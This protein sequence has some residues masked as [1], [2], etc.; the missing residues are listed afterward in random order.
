MEEYYERIKSMNKD[1][2]V[3]LYELFITNTYALAFQ[4]DD[5]KYITKYLPLSK[6]MIEEML[7]QKGAIGC[8]QQ[9][10]KSNM[11][12]WIC[13]DF[14]SPD[15]EN[16]D[17]NY[18]YESC[19]VPLKTICDKYHIRYLTEFS[20]RRGIHLWIIFSHLIP[21]D[22]AFYILSYLKKK[23]ILQIGELKSVNLDLFP[24][25]D[26][27]KGNIV[28]KQ[29][30]L[31]LSI[32]KSGSRSWLFEGQFIN[33]LDNNS[34]TFLESQF[35][36]LKKYKVNDYEKVIKIIGIDKDDYINKLKYIKY[37]VYSGLKLSIRE[38]IDILSR[39]KVYKQIFDRLMQGKAYRQDWLVIMGTFSPLHDGG[40]FVKEMYSIFPN[41]DMKKT[42]DNIGRYIDKYFPATF[43]YLYQIYDLDIEESLNKKDTGYAY[44]LNTYGI[45][46][47]KEVDQIISPK[48]EGEI[49]VEDTL[50]KEI[51]Y[52]LDNDEVL[53][54]SIWNKLNSFKKQDIIYISEI[55]SKVLNGTLE[56]E[57][58]PSAF[59][60]DRRE[61]EMKTRRLVS[62]DAFD[63]VLTTH[64]SLLLQYSIK[65]RWNSF[66]YNLSFCSREDIFYNWYSSWSEYINKIKAFLEVP[67][68]ETYNVFTIDL[69]EFY[70]HIDYL[71]VYSRFQGEFSEKEN[72]LF[73]F[74]IDYN[75]S[76]MRKIYEGKRKGVPQGPAYARIISEMYLD[77]VI[78]SI[79]SKYESST[80]H[81]FRYVDD[82]IVFVKPENDA[83]EMY[84]FLVSNLISYGLPINEEK[85]CCY[86]L[87]KSLTNEQRREILRK[88][89]F[90]YDLQ[91]VDYKGYVTLVERRRD[92]ENF[93]N[94]KT[95]EISDISMFYSTKTYEE[96]SEIYFRRYACKIMES[97]I[98]R[99]SAFRRFYKYMFEHPNVLNEALLKNFF[100]KVPLNSINFGNLLGE[101][102][103]VIQKH[104][105]SYDSL[106]RI[107][108][109]YLNTINDEKLSEEY[110]IL[111]D[112]LKKIIITLEVEDEY[113]L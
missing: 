102:Y 85:S 18:I 31:P 2:S 38:A 71:S 60:Y 7:N 110:R 66:S 1:L 53:N 78:L 54:V 32:H 80:Y 74:L 52:F 35:N 29:V 17:L 111:I 13:F 77:A 109:L 92:I 28:G 24:A 40:R 23:L 87:I 106:E 67:F 69:K 96:A 21:K 49:H 104:Q 86:G 43:E 44:L 73:K 10:Y 19:I 48:N 42:E 8:Y 33:R 30:K 56:I 88:D 45:T 27:S 11:V 89:K 105:I 68:M 3:L 15:K 5:G 83:N 20:G 65:K 100:D 81:L 16:P 84:S 34:E 90:T 94:S 61:N 6:Y 97:S 26:L 55:V 57:W 103:Y 70:D 79:F 112:A 22:K 12:K 64:I 101:L 25:T 46:P 4:R 82:I 14:D 99:G 47:K 37:Q 75:D 107:N 9:C 51:K 36:I 41:Y 95:F 59:F 62:L 39:T 93:L 58:K 108:K 76:L 72:K 98:G 50:R 91:D 63:R 113:G